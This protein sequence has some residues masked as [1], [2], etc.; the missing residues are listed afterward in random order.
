MEQRSSVES[1]RNIPEKS[2]L[3]CDWYCSGIA[4]TLRSRE[5][6]VESSPL[7]WLA[8]A[9]FTIPLL[10][11]LVVWAGIAHRPEFE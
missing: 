11:K 8:I 6:V 9:L 5:S 4:G 10:S 3:T 1:R 7:S 2:L